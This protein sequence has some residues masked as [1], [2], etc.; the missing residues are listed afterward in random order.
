MNS[1]SSTGKDPGFQTEGL[2]A[3]VIVEKLPYEL[4][5]LTITN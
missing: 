1:T 2:S 4:A 5:K 3:I